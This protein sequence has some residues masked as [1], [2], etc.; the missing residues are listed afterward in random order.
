M[1]IIF[2]INIIIIVFVFAII[3]WGV[4]CNAII[5]ESPNVKLVSSSSPT[6][7]KK[8]VCQADS[9]HLFTPTGW[10]AKKNDGQFSLS[11]SSFFPPRQKGHYVCPAPTL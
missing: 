5:T 6:W 4:E 2:N 1:N 11:S 9:A 10:C 3:C 7:A 8:H